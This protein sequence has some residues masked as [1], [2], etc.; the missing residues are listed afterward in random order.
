MT[1]NAEIEINGAPFKW[2]IDQGTFTF[3]GLKSALFLISPSLL[4][5][6]IPISEEIGHDL[7]RL[8]VANSSRQGTDEDYQSMVTVI[9]GS[10]EEGFRNW[11]KAASAAGWGTFELTA[12]DTVNKTARVRISNTW[13][14]LLGNDFKTHWGCPFMQG[15][16]IGIFSH[17]FKKSCWA[18][19]VEISYNPENAYVEYFIYGSEKTITAEIET[20]HLAYFQANESKLAIEIKEKTLELHKSEA[21]YRQLAELSS[22]WVWEMDENLKFSYFSVNYFRRTG[23]DPAFSIGKTR[24]QLTEP[25]DLKRAHWQKHLLDLKN[26]REFRNFQYEFIGPDGIMHYLQINGSPVFDEKNN[27]GGYR[28]TATDLTEK[29]KTVQALEIANIEAEKTLDKI[30]ELNLQLQ[31]EV[32]HSNRAKTRLNH[33]NMYDNLT[34]TPNRSQIKNKLQKLQAN[35]KKDQYLIGLMVLSLNEIEKINLQYGLDVGDTVLVE[36][37]ILI[38]DTVRDDDIVARSGGSDF[39]VLL[40]DCQSVEV[41]KNIAEQIIDNINQPFE[42]VP[43]E[44]IT[45][46]IGI[47]IHPDQLETTEKLFLRAYSATHKAKKVGESIF[48]ASSK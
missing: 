44:I 41:A 6:L 48:I 19:E 28:G 33:V 39:I 23:Y 2:D 3:N 32:A 13:E 22:D 37:S 29:V 24:S 30:S 12:F 17:A 20:L 8:M 14:L 10:F 35:S 5:I 1:H 25:T 27:F 46:C 36:A 26:K 34:E 42:S 21:R 9:G 47:V 18:D 43:D 11:G 7:F 38:K 4:K 16:L 31:T 15:K 45:A 40:P